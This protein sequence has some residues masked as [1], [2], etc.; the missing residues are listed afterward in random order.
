[1]QSVPPWML[2]ATATGGGFGGGVSADDFS[3]LVR[4]GIA[5]EALLWAFLGGWIAH[6][7]ASGRDG[8]ARFPAHRGRG[9]GTHPGQRRGSRQMMLS[10]AI[11][12]L[13]CASTN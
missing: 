7:F 13:G 3:E 12:G 2:G 8:A 1:M 4:I 10:R 9:S 5:M 6:Y 11:T